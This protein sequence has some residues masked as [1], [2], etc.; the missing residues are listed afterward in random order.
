MYYR[1][2][3]NVYID[4]TYNHGHFERIIAA[5]GILNSI[6]D[7]MRNGNI[8]RSTFAVCLYE[9]FMLFLIKYL[10]FYYF[11]FGRNKSEINKNISKR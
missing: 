1:V 3:F 11:A 7:L 8:W 6:N 2:R 4:D 5:V 10:I 9:M